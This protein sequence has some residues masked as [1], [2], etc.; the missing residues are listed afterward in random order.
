MDAGC[1]DLSWKARW[2]K[3]MLCTGISIALKGG[4]MAKSVHLYVCVC[5]RERVYNVCV[6]VRGLVT[7]SQ[8]GIQAVVGAQMT[9][10][11][12]CLG[13]R[14]SGVWVNQLQVCITSGTF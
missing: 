5:V 6:V 3:V 2:E 14:L 11:Q 10:S 13:Q 1:R 12:P 8:Q 9:F 7:V 4:L